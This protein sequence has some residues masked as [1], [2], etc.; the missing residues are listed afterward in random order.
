MDEYEVNLADYLV[1]LW[2]KK[3]VVLVTFLVAVGAGIGLSMRQD[4]Q[5][6]VETAL[7]ILPPLA[8]DV[9]DEVPGTVYSPET[10]K[11]F[12]TGRDLL[13]VVIEEA[14]LEEDGL[15]PNRVERMMSVELDEAA[16]DEF[17]GRFP[18][19]MRATFTGGDREQ[20][21]RLADAWAEAFVEKNAELFM[22][23]IAQSFD[24]ISESFSEVEEDLR[25][26]QAEL[27]EL[28]KESQ[29]ELL[30]AELAALEEVYAEH[31][32]EL[33]LSQRELAQAESRLALLEGFQEEPLRYAL[34]TGVLDRAY[35]RH[36]DE[37]RGKERQLGRAQ[38]R[39]ASLEE[40][41]AEEPEHYALQRGVSP[42]ALWQFLGGG[43]GQRDE[44]ELERFLD[45]SIEEQVLNTAYI[46]LRGDVVSAR[47]EVEE[48][49]A[50]IAHLVG[51][52]EALWALVDG[53]G[54]AVEDA[55]AADQAGVRHLLQ[56]AEYELGAEVAAAEA[57]V[58]ELSSDVT[59]LQEQADDT[60][61]R[62]EEMRT[63]LIAVEAESD[64]LTQE[65]GVL[66]RSYER[67]GDKLQDARLAQAETAEPIR[68]VEEA[69]PETVRT[70]SP[71]GRRMSVAV[72]GVLGLFAGVLLAFVV[73]AIQERQAEV[74]SA[75]GP[76]E[77]TAGSEP[78]EEG[79]PS[80][81]GEGPEAPQ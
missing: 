43:V 29:A 8:A 26:K 65:I 4:D 30:K 72:G 51:E 70:I 57:E 63:R 80:D 75:S 37:L 74:A 68:V 2:R 36:I 45:L 47:A 53:G 49:E 14:E 31:L 38:V 20:L 3:W 77:A 16:A 35:S 71:P 13:Q 48:L 69:L 34:G 61:L 25:A 22:S 32:R 55:P 15:T 5:Y 10:Y 17:P 21:P 60:K 52:T 41:L 27:Q 46:D 7:L 59:S 24:Y 1:V 67:M 78:G 62:L 56:A 33:S 58:D 18:L 42:D 54:A 39:L 12:A 40:A 11:R 79:P 28:Q 9:A 64:R 23:R 50:D 76:P 66:E 44:E 81:K 6:R 73:H 19:Y